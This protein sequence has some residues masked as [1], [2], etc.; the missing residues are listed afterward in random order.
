MTSL[1]TFSGKVLAQKSYELPAPASPN[2][3][4]P[5]RLTDGDHPLLLLERR[6][7]GLHDR[8]TPAAELV[9]ELEAHPSELAPGTPL[10]VRRALYQTGHDTLLYRSE[11]FE[12]ALTV[13][14]HS[15]SHTTLQANLTFTHPSVHRDDQDATVLVTGRVVIDA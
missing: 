11:T 12:G 13:L 1:D 6:P 7:R 3:D 2:E 4:P 8:A 14:A 15:G 10:H 5:L 9:A